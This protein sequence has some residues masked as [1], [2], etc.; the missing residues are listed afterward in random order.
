MLCLCLMIEKLSKKITERLYGY[1]ESPFKYIVDALSGKTVIHQPLPKPVILGRPNGDNSIVF[2][3]TVKRKPDAPIPIV[4]RSATYVQSTTYSIKELPNTFQ[5]KQLSA[6]HIV[7]DKISLISTLIQKYYS[8]IATRNQTTEKFPLEVTKYF[9]EALDYKIDYKGNNSDLTPEYEKFWKVVLFE[10][11]PETARQIAEAKMVL[12]ALSSEKDQERIKTEIKDEKGDVVKI[13]FKVDIFEERLE[14][15]R[16]IAIEIQLLVYN[17]D[18]TD[19]FPEPPLISINEEIRQCTITCNFPVVIK[20][21]PEG[22]SK[23][24]V[25]QPGVYR[26]NPLREL[27]PMRLNI[28]SPTSSRNALIANGEVTQEG[29]KHLA[30]SIN[31][32]TDIYNVSRVLLKPI[33]SELNISEQ[34]AKTEK[35]NRI[36]SILNIEF[37]EGQEL[38]FYNQ[39]LSL[40]SNFKNIILPNAKQIYAYFETLEKNDLRFELHNNLDSSF[41]PRTTFF[42]FDDEVLNIVRDAIL[43]EIEAYNLQIG[44][45]N[46]NYT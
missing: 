44:S 12:Y 6:Y 29:V 7:F 21:D 31:Q 45:V 2:Q 41:P 9:A 19:D 17:L 14:L 11:I 20:A 22:R 46:P 35:L 36:S 5:E 3:P 37:V 8:A 40:I 38:T 32:Y 18:K 23:D 43:G 15:L 10:W 25:R 33:S 30:N 42:L 24:L 1:R 27:G 13:I 26:Y 34:E 16:Q 28:L 39:V 4:D